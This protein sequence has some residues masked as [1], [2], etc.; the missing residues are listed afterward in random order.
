ML[1]YIDKFGD[2]GFE[3]AM[4]G[5]VLISAVE[6]AG[7]NLMVAKGKYMRNALKEILEKDFK[8]A[9]KQVGYNTLRAGGAA[10]G[11]AATEGIQTAVEQSVV[12]KF[13]YKEY[14]ESMGSGLLMGFVLPTGGAMISQS[15]NTINDIG[16][17]ILLS[18]ADTKANFKTN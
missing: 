6:A 14:V 10:T 13:D 2:E 8:Q 18:D 1:S 5:G 17:S 3:K 12:G 15:I 9:M 11:E 16:K 4:A 7:I